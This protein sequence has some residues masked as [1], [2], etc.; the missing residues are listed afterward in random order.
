MEWALIGAP[1]RCGNK[2]VSTDQNYKVA[3]AD[4]MIVMPFGKILIG[5]GRPTM[6]I[7]EIG[8]NHE[9]SVDTCALMVEAAV[10]AGADAVKLQTSDPDEHYLPG[11]PSYELYDKA[12]LK[13]E[14]TT[15]IFALAKKL[16]VEVF[17]TCGDMPTLDLIESLDPAGHKISSGM[18]VNLPMIRRFAK[19]GRPLIFSSGMSDL[20]GVTK[21]VK[22]A[23]MAGAE[24]IAVL[25]C[26]SLYPAEPQ[27]LNLRAIRTLREHFGTLTGFSDH[28]AG[29]EAAPLA[30]AAGACI[31]ERHFT[32]DRSRSGFDHIVSL[33]P[34]EFAAMVAAIRRAEIIMGTGIKVPTDAESEFAR[35][36]SRRLVAR[37]DIKAR[38]VISED[39]LAVKRTMVEDVGLPALAFDD[40]IGSIAVRDL[41]KFTVISQ[42]DLR[43]KE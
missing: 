14:E 15:S 41:P 34:A 6:V 22:A 12:R 3:T 26:T 42:D 23:K 9:G 19:T 27:T 10:R 7:A 40:V 32:F 21:A 8:I 4:K 13:P 36:W 31:I 1:W 17:T 18:L 20:D 30:I 33:E 28:S 39:D 35:R 11:T 16:G 38:Q 24:Q 2:S 5:D 43:G 29:I 25:Q 37:R